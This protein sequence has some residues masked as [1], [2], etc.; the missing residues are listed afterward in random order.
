MDQGRKTNSFNY[1]VTLNITKQ[2]K[3]NNKATTNSLCDILYP[4][5]HIY[6]IKYMKMRNY[7]QWIL[8][9]KHIRVHVGKKF[10]STLIIKLKI[11]QIW[12]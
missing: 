4:N 1:Q 8:F 12:V 7:I 2:Q 5:I 10:T 3:P 6:I 11:Y 9:S